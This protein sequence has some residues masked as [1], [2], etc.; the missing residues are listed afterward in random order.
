MN[1]YLNDNI[2]T[3]DTVKNY[4]SKKKY[5]VVVLSPG[6]IQETKNLK[7]NDE[8][9]K[10]WK[11]KYH[12]INSKTKDKYSKSINFEELIKEFKKYQERI[13]KINS[14]ILIKI[15]HKIRLFSF[16]QPLII[17]FSDHN[18]TYSYSIIDGLLDLKDNSIKPDITM[19]SQALYF[20]FKYEFGFDTLTVNGCFKTDQ[21]GLE[22]TIKSLSIEI[23]N[24][25]GIK[26]N[27][28]L[29]FN[30]NLIFYFF[31]NLSALK[32]KNIELA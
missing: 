32:K 12:L 11:D 18:K 21:K 20:I 9:L 14:A 26:L 7:Q 23:L 30:F 6:E 27:L 24:S 28:K 31:K 1:F 5:N 15:L 3:P 8:S 19:H 17:K 25:M 4:F 29:I 13:F 16:F 10:F 22:K 2:N